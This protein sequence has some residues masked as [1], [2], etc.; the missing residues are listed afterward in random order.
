MNVAQEG[1]S[2]LVWIGD[3]NYPAPLTHWSDNPFLLTFDN[4]N[5][6][7]GLLAFWFGTGAD[8]ASG[9]AGSKI[10]DAFTTD[11]GRSERAG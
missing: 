10:A 2:L 7:P 6:A 11:Y 4:P 8:H 9:F 1:D 3:H 5:I